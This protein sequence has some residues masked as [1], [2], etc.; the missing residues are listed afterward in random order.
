MDTI[1]QDVRYAVRT[2]LRARTFA[3]A[4]ILTLGIGIGA[5][6]MIF[7][8]V[9][10]TLLRP[11]PFGD[12]DRLALITDHD[13]A[14]HGTGGQ[15][16]YPTF[17][18]WEA[19]SA[20]FAGMAAYHETTLTVR[21]A[22][23][24]ERLTG[25]QVSGAL[26]RVL[27][28]AAAHGRT[29]DP[30]DEADGAAPVA[31]LSWAVWQDRF[32]GADV[33]GRSV[34][35]N[36]VAHTIIGVMPAGFA[37]PKRSRVWVPLAPV[38]SAE[39]G[40]HYLSVVGRLHDGVSFAAADAELRTIAER[41]GAMYAENRERQ[42]RVE[43]LHAALVSEVRPVMLLLLG[44]VAFVLLIVCANVANLL[45]ARATAR[46]REL[47]VRA[48]L[49]AS[50]R[51]LIRQLL[52]ESVVLA[53]AGAGI[54]VLLSLWWVDL[55]VRAMP[56]ELPFWLRLGVDARVLAF[57]AATAIATALLFGLAPALFA[58]RTERGTALRERGA[59][60]GAAQGR[61]RGAFVVAQLAASIILLIG[62][63]LMARSFLAVRS[64]DP[65]FATAGV[66]TAR[67]SPPPSAYPGAPE[68]NAFYEAL[69]ERLEAQPAI[70][71]AELT[72]AFPLSGTSYTSNFSI[73]GI[74][75]IDNI[76]VFNLSVSPGYFAAAGIRVLSG[77]S[78]T[79]GDRAGAERVA[80]VNDA[81]A[82]RYFPGE[83]PIGR[84]IRFGG[85]AGGDFHRIVGVV[86]NVQQRELGETY[87]RG[88]IYL[89]FAQAP[90]PDVTL[91]VRTAADD[92]GAAVGALALAALGLY[93][94]IAYGVAQRTREIGVRVALGATAWQVLGLVLRQGLALT[95]TGLVIGLGSAAVLGRAM[96][97]MLYGVTT[98]DPLTFLA[99]PC[100]LTAIALLAC[101]LPARRATRIDAA[102]ALRAD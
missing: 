88:A 25:A 24:A 20:S 64:L 31:L 30:A 70:A 11:L 6:T 61:L 51:R 8:L 60:G 50:D 35:I 7:S 100:V 98:H 91:V 84:G 78:F 16:S 83:D 65:G 74:G 97:G 39:R 99:V 77:R 69:R 19:Q 45:L 85:G 47:A 22:D 93:G 18:D 15:V 14:R 102:A 63:L 33:V 29:F 27:G 2:L 28:A 42:A 23:D 43:P 67:V 96:Q 72:N 89:P 79:A 32:G 56:A 36:G 87:V 12:H 95:G 3:A 68:L 5:V 82:R 66:L 38:A 34:A 9:N 53:L 55:I 80:I 75:E 52:T 71:S 94:V 49:G 76:S 21:L 92:A 44:A 58:G 46:G 4:A 90:W 59:S 10:G 86:A 73:D 13:V 40:M 48:A 57:A 101:W 81:I 41:L 62:G 1:V 37:F 17:R 54:G 26:F